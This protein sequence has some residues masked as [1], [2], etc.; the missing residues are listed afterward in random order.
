MSRKFLI[1]LDGSGIDAML[2]AIE[3][4]KRW[5]REKTEELSRR[6]A[7]MGATRAEVNF[8]ASYYSGDID[9]KVSVEPKGDGAYV[10]KAEGETVLFVEF[11]T[12][13]IGYG[14]PEPSGYGPGTF[15][16]TD[17]K[18]PRW[19]QPGG[20]FYKDTSGEIHHTH[21]NPPNMPMYRSVRELEMELNR[22][23]QEVFTR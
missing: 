11:G 9:A 22:L 23:V 10:V 7:E 13:L 20:W 3:D 18:H 2:T 4:E 1:G 16:P 15:P 6:L 12:G 17:P 5:L 19:N 14:H 8:A 21:G